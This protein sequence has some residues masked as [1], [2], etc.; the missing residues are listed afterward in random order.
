[1]QTN[2][3]LTVFYFRPNRQCISH[4]YQTRSICRRN[5]AS[6]WSKLDIDV[7]AVY[8]NY[9]MLNFHHSIYVCLLIYLDLLWVKIVSWLGAALTLPS[10]IIDT[11]TM[12]RPYM[13]ADELCCL[14]VQLQ[15]LVCFQNRTKDNW[16][17]FQY[18]TCIT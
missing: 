14:G 8:M 12:Q 7:I 1:M 18:L 5:I 13:G 9:T 10:Y 15:F 2:Y 3:R 6:N 16:Y 11:W 4:I 17:T